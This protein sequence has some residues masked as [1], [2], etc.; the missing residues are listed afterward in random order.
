MTLNDFDYSIAYVAESYSVM[1]IDSKG[2]KT[3]AKNTGP[4]FGAEVIKLITS[5]EPGDVFLFTD[6]QAKLLKTKTNKVVNI[7]DLS[8]IIQ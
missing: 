1:R 5:V 3:K 4:A 8:V 6:I 2:I 7:N